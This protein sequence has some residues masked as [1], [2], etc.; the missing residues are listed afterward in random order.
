M[1]IPLRTQYAIRALVCLAMKR[2]EGVL[3]GQRIATLGGIP[4]KYVEQVMRDL[5][6]GGFVV[7]QRGRGGGYLLSRPAPAI[8]VLEVIETLDGPLEELG[9][10][11]DRDPGG[12]L[13]E[14]A[15]A[16][17]RSALR[18]AL[19]KESIAS[20]ADRAAPSTYHI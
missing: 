6:Q 14:P 4:R 10:S 20:V 15:W 11:R 8:T 5:R 7:S 1:D 18:E 2:G 13:L 3:N 16:A 17:V 12:A 9:R 19:E